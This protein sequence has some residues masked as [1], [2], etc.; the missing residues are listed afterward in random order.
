MGETKT[1]GTLFAA[2]PA[3]ASQSLEALD[4][5]KD[6]EPML[7]TR[8]L[9]VWFVLCVTCCPPKTGFLFSSLQRFPRLTDT[10]I[11]QVESI[12]NN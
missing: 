2:E 3:L 5:V 10:S 11:R 7:P 1:N 4:G 8:I 9:L 12:S 6:F